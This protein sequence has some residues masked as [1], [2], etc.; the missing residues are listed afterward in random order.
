[1]AVGQTLRLSGGS[2]SD[3][4]QYTQTELGSLTATPGDNPVAVHITLSRGDSVAP[5]FPSTITVA[6]VSISLLTSVAYDTAGSVQIAIGVYVGYGSW[7]GTG[8]DTGAL[9]YTAS[10]CRVDVIELTGADKTTPVPSGQYASASAAIDDGQTLS[11]TLP[12]APASTSRC[13]ACVGRNGTGTTDLATR[14]N[15]TEISVDSHS[16]PATLLKSDW[17]SDAAEQTGSV[18]GN[19]GI[20][21]L[22][23]GIIV[24]EVAEAAGVAHEGEAPL[25]AVAT[26]SPQGSLGAGGDAILQAVATPLAEGSLLAGGEAPLIA[27]ATLGADGSAV[28]GGQAALQGVGL[29]SAEGVRVLLGAAGLDA[30]AVLTADGSVVVVELAEAALQGIAVLTVSGTLVLGTE[31]LLQAV[32]HMSF[33]PVLVT[34]RTPAYRTAHGGFHPAGNRRRVRLADETKGGRI[35]G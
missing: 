20:A 9:G 3:L 29:L 25:Q 31:T 11:A 8:I 18:T 4:S 32:A 14:T 24:Y 30:V 6:G 35:I 17:R 2:N 21:A 7:S 1:M 33:D 16:A 19:T 27:V 5:S 22:R 12:S 34:R 26:I 13:F 10:G 23:T 28:F 15:W